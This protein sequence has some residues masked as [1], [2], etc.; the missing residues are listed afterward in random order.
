VF[1]LKLYTAVSIVL[2]TLIEMFYK[3]KKKKDGYAFHEAH[4]VD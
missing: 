3:L 1:Y 2:V 4:L